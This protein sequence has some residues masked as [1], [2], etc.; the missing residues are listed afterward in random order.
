MPSMVD[1]TGGAVL[2]AGNDHGSGSS[3]PTAK[4]TPADPS[5]RAG[6]GVGE[7]MTLRDVEQGRCAPC[8]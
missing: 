8:V 6:L 2:Q 5:S 7:E 4:V 1:G 3:D